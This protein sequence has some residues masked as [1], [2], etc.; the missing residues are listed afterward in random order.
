MMAE[1]VEVL[2][3]GYADGIVTRREFIQRAVVLT[4]SLAAATSLLDSIV[5]PLS[6][7][8]AQ[9]DPEES[10]LISQMVQFSGPAGAVFGYQT[11]PKSAG[12]YPAVIVI[13][14][15]DGLDEHIQDVA[16]RYAKE[17]FVA[18][19]MDYLSRH[20]GT[21]KVSGAGGDIPNISNLAPLEV[22]K[23]D[24]EAAL[25]Y[26]RGLKEVRGDR[27]GI[28]G[29]CW[30]GGRAFYAATQVRSFRAVVVFY[31]RSPNPL[32]LVKQIEA[33]VLAHYGELD[34]RITD[35]APETEAAMKQYGKSYEYKIYS[36]AGHAFHNDTGRRYH[37]EAAKEAWN[38]T[39]EFFKKHLQS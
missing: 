26:L 20:G 19:A 31:G 18:L 16:R 21:K 11:Q 29:F 33:P 2:V 27:I 35:G 36:G 6:A 39:I 7:N 15:N 22:V 17:G 37:P 12:R 10:T 24:T 9:V 30:G 23:D 13:H 5:L 1:T 32:D 28:T 34:K 38:R 25:T 8:A 3:K 14:G 4:G